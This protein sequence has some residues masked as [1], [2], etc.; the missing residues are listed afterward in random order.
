VKKECR[1]SLEATKA[2]LPRRIN[3][4]L[5]FLVQDREFVGIKSKNPKME[6]SGLS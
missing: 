5:E 4:E 6:A 1:A 3:P 2:A